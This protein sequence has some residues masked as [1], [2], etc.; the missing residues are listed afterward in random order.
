MRA[1]NTRTV[2]AKEAGRSGYPPVIKMRNGRF[3]RSQGA[4]RPGPQSTSGTNSGSAVSAANYA[5]RS[6]DGAENMLRIIVDRP[7]AGAFVAGSDVTGSVQIDTE[8]DKKFKY[9]HISLTGRAQVSNL[10]HT[11]CMVTSSV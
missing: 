10:T 6:G 8:E 11:N 9:I 5:V 2:M 3:S 1:R 7:S 4:A